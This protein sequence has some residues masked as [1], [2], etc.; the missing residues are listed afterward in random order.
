MPP[1]PLAIFSGGFLV[2][3]ARYLS[4]AEHLASWGYVVLLYDKVEVC[5][6]G[7][8]RGEGEGS[9]NHCPSQLALGSLQPE[10]S[11]SAESASLRQLSSQTAASPIGARGRSCTCAHSPCWTQEGPPARLQ[12]SSLEMNFLTDVVSVSFVRDLIDWSSTHACLSRLTS[13]SRGVYLVGEQ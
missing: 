12:V 3:A 4:Y 11:L 1:Y 9:H 7:G 6:S 13:P 10:G 2:P 5:G 8:S